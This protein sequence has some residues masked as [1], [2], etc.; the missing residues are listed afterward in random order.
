MLQNLGL[1]HGSQL[2]S[3]D[4]DIGRILDFQFD[5]RS[6]IIRYVVVEAG[7]WLGGR[8]LLISPGSFAPDALAPNPNGYGQFHVNLRR[9]MVAESPPYDAHYPITRLYEEEYHQYYGMP[10][11]WRSPVLW[12]GSD[13]EVVAV[14]EASPVPDLDESR[15]ELRSANAFKGTSIHAWDGLMGK[16]A[17]FR[18]DSASWTIREL[19]LETGHWYF[20]KEIRVRTSDVERLRKEPSFVNVHFMRK[21]LRETL[22]H[23]VAHLETTT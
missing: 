18:F 16:L 12:R 22:S 15:A 6:W 14:S 8:K 2:R 17:D 21:D 1:F 23:H 20:G 3:M 19:L 10:P 7:A 5:A 11:Y 13:S 4:G 9:Q